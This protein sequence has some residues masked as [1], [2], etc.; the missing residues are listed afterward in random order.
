[1]IGPGVVR[2]IDTLELP[3][4]DPADIAQ[5]MGRVLAERID[6]QQP[7]ADGDPR[8]AV[9]LDGKSGHLFLTQ[10]GTNGN[11]LETAPLFTHAHKTPQIRFPDV[12][13]C[14]E[15]SDGSVQVLNLFA[16]D[17]QRAGGVIAR[18]QHSIGVV[19]QSPRGGERLESDLIVTGQGGQMRIAS[20][21][22]LDQPCDHSEHG[23]QHQNA[24][25]DS[26]PGKEPAL[27]G[28]VLEGQLHHGPGSAVSGDAETPAQVPQQHEYPRP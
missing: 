7:G 20:D 11:L 9:A 1:M 28:V 14:S 23:H 10:V 2:D 3:R 27:P 8:K 15:L 24:G 18:E 17:F 12:D 16:D 26:S 21:L 4:V 13:E 25:N 6:A 22:Q 19:N 5:H